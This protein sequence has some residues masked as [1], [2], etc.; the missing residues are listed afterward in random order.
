M[1]NNKINILAKHS[2][3]IRIAQ[4]LFEITQFRR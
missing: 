4:A 1:N 3:G 2:S